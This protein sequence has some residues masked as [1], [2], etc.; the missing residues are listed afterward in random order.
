MAPR[1]GGVS[2]HPHGRK[3]KACESVLKSRK[4]NLPEIGMSLLIWLCNLF[5]ESLN[6][7]E[8]KK[9]V[10]LE[11]I[12]SECSIARENENGRRTPAAEE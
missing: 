2:V 8:A 6:L 3:G 7:H 5:L 12:E 10:G 4:G 9:V 11:Q 1:E